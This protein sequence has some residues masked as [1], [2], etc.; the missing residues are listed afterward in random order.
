MIPRNFYRNKLGYAID[1]RIASG[2]NKFSHLAN[3][4]HDDVFYYVKK[5]PELNLTNLTRG[6]HYHL[7][8]FKDLVGLIWVSDDDYSHYDLVELGP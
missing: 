1:L 4:V 8:I 5:E 7:V 3:I 2:Q 6:T